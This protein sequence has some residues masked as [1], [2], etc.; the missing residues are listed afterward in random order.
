MKVLLGVCG[1]VAAYKAAEIVRA[2]QDKGVEVEVTLTASAERFITPLTFNALTGKRVHTSL[3]S[4]DQSEFA[5]GPIEHIAVAQAIDAMLIAPATATTMARLA[6]GFADDFLSSVYL[7][8]TA[9]VVLAPALNVNMWEHPATQA[10][11]AQLLARGVHLVT[12]ESGYLACGMTG[13]GRLANIDAIVDATL[14]TAGPHGDDLQGETV[15]IT[16]GGTR[17]ALDPVRFLGNRSS[18]RMGHALAEAALARGAR[19]LLVTASSLPAPSGCSVTRVESAAEMETA[20]KAL[21]SQATVVIAAA[22]VADFRPVTP[23]AAK[24]RRASGLTLHLEP[25][26]DLVAG[27]VRDRRPGTLVIAFA[28]ETEHVEQNAREKLLRKGVDGIV[29]NDVS[30]S[31]IG[32]DSDQNSGLFLTPDGRFALPKESKRSMADRILSQVL[33]LRTQR[34][35]QVDTGVELV[36]I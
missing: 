24:L 14:A 19:V 31:G 12:P 36:S 9:P 23:S 20:L 32:F 22:A 26:P 34:P 28:A 21:L 30:E 8:T 3:W 33:S 7:A 29:A 13:G 2:L 4:P 10:N 1:S 18:G 17:E 11:V 6:H 5:E 15:L 25:T 27:A 16:A 35:L